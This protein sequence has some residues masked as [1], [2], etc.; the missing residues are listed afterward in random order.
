M[1]RQPACARV[2]LAPGEHIVPIPGTKRIRYLDENLGALDLKLSAAERAEISA[3]F[4]PD[5]IAGTRYPA[6]MMGALGR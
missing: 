2:V 4:P 3:V 6:A 1:Y 5:S